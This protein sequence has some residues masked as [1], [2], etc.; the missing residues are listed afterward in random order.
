MTGFMKP[1]SLVSFTVRFSVGA[2]SGLRASFTGTNIRC[3]R[4]IN[5]YTRTHIPF[6][7][8]HDPVMT[9]TGDSDGTSRKFGLEPEGTLLGFVLRRSAACDLRAHECTAYQS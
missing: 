7:H 3:H 5:T 1:P 2:N 9:T 6:G 4:H 8:R